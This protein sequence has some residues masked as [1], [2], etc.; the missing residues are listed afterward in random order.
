MKKTISLLL[1]LA[2]IAIAAASNLALLLLGLRLTKGRDPET[3]A[4][5]GLNISS[6]NIGTFVLPFVQSF[7]P[8]AALVGVSMFDAGNALMCVGGT[9]AIASGIVGKNDRPGLGP[10]IRKTFTSVPLWSYMIMMVISAAHL[11]LPRVILT[12]ADIVGGANGFLAM[13][14]LGI[15]FELKLPKGQGK[16][17]CPCNN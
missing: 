12:F 15:G 3:Q 10:V 4:V 6:Y 7:L 2:L 9:Y 1:I 16:R 5:Y 14:M 8:A 11:T 17:I 13:L